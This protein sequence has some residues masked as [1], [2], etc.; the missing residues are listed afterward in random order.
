MYEWLT[1]T[2]YICA[3]L[4][5]QSQK[6]QGQITKESYTVEYFHCSAS[7]FMYL[8]NTAQQC[9][10]FRLIPHWKPNE[11]LRILT[12]W[13]GSMLAFRILIW[14]RSK[15]VSTSVLEK[16]RKATTEACNLNTIYLLTTYIGVGENWIWVGYRIF[17]I[18]QVFVALVKDKNHV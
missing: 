2:V 10:I 18:S 7:C 14:K 11:I 5:L 17:C 3:L 1:C 13:S 8:Q 4:H 6:L 12:A 16:P 9:S 15:P